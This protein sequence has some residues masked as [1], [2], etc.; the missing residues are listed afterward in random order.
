M[1][2]ETN[3]QIPRTTNL[4]FQFDKFSHK[5]CNMVGSCTVRQNSA[6]LKIACTTA[7]SPSI[8]F[9]CPSFQDCYVLRYCRTHLQVCG[10][11]YSAALLANN[12]NIT[13]KPHGPVKISNILCWLWETMHVQKADIW[14]KVGQ[15]SCKASSYLRIHLKLYRAGGVSLFPDNTDRTEGNS[16]KLY[17]GRFR[18]VTWQN[19]F[20]EGVMRHWNRLPGGGGG[21]TVPGGIQEMCRCSTEGHG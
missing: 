11:L 5:I 1:N 12:M 8:F 4:M 15:K 3:K 21:V 13:V 14:C 16:L 7:H 2:K 10:C 9:I 17:Q 20:S 6:I 19:L 18:M